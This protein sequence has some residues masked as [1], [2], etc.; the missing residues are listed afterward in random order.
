ME[1]TQLDSIQRKL[2]LRFGNEHLDLMIY[3]DTEG[4]YQMQFSPHIHQIELVTNI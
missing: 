2:N 1:H 4:E 3:D